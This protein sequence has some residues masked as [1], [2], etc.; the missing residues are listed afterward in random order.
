MDQRTLENRLRRT[1]SGRVDRRSKG[2]R[3][4][5]QVTDEVVA[6]AK[7]LAV[8]RLNKGDATGN[9]VRNIVSTVG[10][11]GLPSAA[12]VARDPVTGRAYS[13]DIE[14]GTAN[15]G[16]GY[17]YPKESKVLVIPTGGKQKF[18][19]ARVIK[20]V[21]VFETP[22]FIFAPRVKGQKANHI[23]RDAA[24]R[25]AARYGLRFNKLR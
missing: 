19:R 1:L 23:M 2:Y 13:A 5:V 20:G 6:E 4:V 12:A 7:L 25:V 11:D 3:Q 22:P 16:R 15:G 14:H 18:S 24:M 8:A 21:E 9:Y 10:P 17:I